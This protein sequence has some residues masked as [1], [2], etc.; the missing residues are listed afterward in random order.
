MKFNALRLG[1][2]ASG[3]SRGMHPRLKAVLPSEKIGFR[4]FHARYGVH[5]NTVFGLSLSH[6][7]AVAV[8]D[9]ELLEAIETCANRLYGSD[10]G[11]R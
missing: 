7:F 1:S 2:F 5:Y 9:R 6:D 3:T 11:R 4:V 10:V 8:G